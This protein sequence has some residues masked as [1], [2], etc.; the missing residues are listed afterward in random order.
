[1]LSI[2]EPY[3]SCSFS[4]FVLEKGWIE[5]EKEDEDD[6]EKG[7]ALTYVQSSEA[8]LPVNPRVARTSTSVG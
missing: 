5:H 4:S 2:P 8:Y 3:A 6:R 1:V 7:M